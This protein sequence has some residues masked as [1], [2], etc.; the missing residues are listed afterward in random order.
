MSDKSGVPRS[1]TYRAYRVA[2]N[3][4][5]EGPSIPID[6]QDDEEAVTTATQLMNGHSIEL[7]DLGRLVIRLPAQ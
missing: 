4:R 6:A 5:V 2:D 7:W 1:V 3:G